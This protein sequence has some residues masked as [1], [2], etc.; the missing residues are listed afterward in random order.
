[1]GMLCL[2]GAFSASAVIDDSREKQELHLIGKKS[3][4]KEE[5][6]TGT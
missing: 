6:R 5:Y 1:M 4:G 2:S 3:L